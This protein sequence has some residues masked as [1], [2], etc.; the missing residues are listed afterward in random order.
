M[1]NIVEEIEKSEYDILKEQVELWKQKY[2][3]QC[4]KMGAYKAEV[5]KEVREREEKIKWKEYEI[6]R[7][8]NFLQNNNYEDLK[9]KREDIDK[10]KREVEKNDF[11]NRKQLEKDF[12]DMKEQIINELSQELI[13]WTEEND[14][15][16]Q[17]SQGYIIGINKAKKIVRENMKFTLKEKPVYVEVKMI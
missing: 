10:L 15:D 14:V 16:N 8:E 3:S 4:G 11:N 2:R 6:E 7:K 9:E 1:N 13:R 5:A 17:R 12:E